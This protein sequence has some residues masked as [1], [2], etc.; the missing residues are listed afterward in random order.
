[1][2][3]SVAK[4]AWHLPYR[5]GADRGDSQ[6]IEMRRAVQR[7]VFFSLGGLVAPYVPWRFR[8]APWLFAALGLAVLGCWDRLARG[9][10]FDGIL[11]GLAAYELLIALT[12]PLEPSAGHSAEETR[13]ATSLGGDSL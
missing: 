2:L 4:P 3:T 5:V 12:L 11:L 1:M 13:R 8:L 7:G 6:R 10:S 9:G